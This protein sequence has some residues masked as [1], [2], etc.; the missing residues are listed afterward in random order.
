MKYDPERRGYIP[1]APVRRVVE[2]WAAENWWIDERVNYGDK[3]DIGTTRLLAEAIG[4]HQD[5]IG[6]LRAGKNNWI[7][8]DLAD[9]IVTFID[10]WLWRRD[11]ELSRIYQDFNLTYLDVIRPTSPEA[12]ELA[13]L[14]FISSR[15]AAAVLGMRAS[16][17]RAQRKRRAR[18]R[19]EAAA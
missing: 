5:T 18:Q 10:P 17:V 14:D 7:D 15:H 2:M 13:L 6:H 4:V 3:T 16:A 19:E 8:F 9:N 12:D 11:E 1:A